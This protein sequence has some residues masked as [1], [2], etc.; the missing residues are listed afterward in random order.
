MSSNLKVVL[1]LAPCILVLAPTLRSIWFA[2]RVS[3]VTNDTLYRLKLKHGDIDVEVFGNFTTA[4]G[5]EYAVSLSRGPAF[6]FSVP[7][8]IPREGQTQV[9]GTVF[10]STKR[11]GFAHGTGR[12]DFW[13]GHSQGSGSHSFSR[14]TV[15]LW[16][17]IAATALP[18]ML[19]LYRRSRRLKRQQ[20]GLCV[21]C[22][23]D[24]RATPQ[25]CPE[26]GTPAPAR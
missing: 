1:S 20:M 4:K 12:W 15:P 13:V 23:Y 22:G 10:S 16:P 21:Q 6:E 14:T 7:S 5:G 8:S 19:Y 18:P 11:L 2:D 26:C 25:R 24:L 17:L 9:I 3:W